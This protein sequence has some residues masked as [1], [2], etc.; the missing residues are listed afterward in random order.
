MVQNLNKKNLKFII[1]GLIFLIISVFFFLNQNYYNKNKEI[2]NYTEFKGELINFHSLIKNKIQNQHNKKTIGI[3][4]GQ[5]L[6]S[7]LSE[8]GAS[9]KEI[10][11]ISKILRQYISLKQLN[12]NQIFE[13]L[14]NKNTG[15]IIR[16][17][18]NLDNINSLHIFKK[19]NKFVANKIEKVL[20]KKTVLG[21][22]LIKS[23]LFQA[24]QKENIDAEVVV[25]FARIFGFEIDFQRDIRKNDI[26]QIVY[27]KY[28]DD[29]GE[30]QK[31]G[32]IIYAYMKNRGREI[33]LYRFV[34][35]K[36]IP[37]YY[38]TNGKSIEKALM[39]TPINGARLSSTYGMRKHPI[40]GYNKMHRGTDFAAPKGTPIMASGSGIIE[41]AK[42]NG[43]YGKYIRIRHNSKYKT[44]YAHLNG[45]ARGIKRGAKVRQGQIIGYVGSTGRSTG[46]HLHYE[47]LVNGKRM[48]SQRLKLPSG[49]TLRG[50]DRE[51]FEISRIKIDV[52]RSNLVN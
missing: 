49:R 45:Y 30:L 4:K 23:S 28:V 47:V 37:G 48:N 3:K 10:F 5:S 16:L 8:A 34:D 40:L 46:P 7:I 31:N 18:V 33:A 50:E 13:I 38:Q 21:E 12:T 44:A 6:N 52:M 1:S 43:A 19:D 51:K 32:E 42:W 35:Q 24:A 15:E 17:T 39:K 20:Y 41:M 27:D 29:D 9:Q 22:G 14:T 2:K 25:D 11:N 26:F 36:G